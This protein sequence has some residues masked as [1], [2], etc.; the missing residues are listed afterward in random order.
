MENLLYIPVIL[1]LAIISWFDLRKSEIP[2]SAWVV[3]PLGLAILYRAVLGTWSLV[4]LALIIA[5]ASER[6]V[7]SRLLRLDVI[8]HVR[9]WI[10]FL[11]PALWWSFPN[12]PYTSLSILAFWIAWEFGWW[13][14]ADATVAI[15]LF[16]ILPAPT[17]LF[18]FVLVHLI[19]VFILT[20]RSLLLGKSLHL[21]RIPGLPLLFIST[22]T[23]LLFKV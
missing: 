10:P 5:A 11:I 7:L 14:G 12:H 21:H 18:A 1:W 19:T 20:V 6:A 17:L 4:L 3:I 8:M 15:C 16:L 22:I 2:H 23:I 9:S 13:G